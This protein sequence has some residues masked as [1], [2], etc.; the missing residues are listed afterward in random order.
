MAFVAALYAVF[1]AQGLMLRILVPTAAAL[2]ALLFWSST[3]ACCSLPLRRLRLSSWP[4]EILKVFVLS[5][6]ML[7]VMSGEN[8]VRVEATDIAAAVIFCV[9][10]GIVCL[11]P[12]LPVHP[13]FAGHSLMAKAF[14][15]F[16]WRE[17]S[18]FL[19]VFAPLLVLHDGAPLFRAAQNKPDSMSEWTQMDP[20]GTVGARDD[21]GVLDA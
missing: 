16:A 1:S 5:C 17:P 19:T 11:S 8:V 14:W 18:G 7:A 12:R 21:V 2:W 13:A 15:L 9:G 10:A 3:R 20:S 6:P 4:A